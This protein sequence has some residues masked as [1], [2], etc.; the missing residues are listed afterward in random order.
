MEGEAAAFYFRYLFGNGFTRK[1]INKINS[2]LN[3]GY[4]IFRGAIARALVI[5]GFHP[6]L[7]LFHANEHNAFNLADDVIEPFCP[8]VDLYVA[9]NFSVYDS[10]IDL[11]PREEEKRDYVRFR[12][13]I[14]KRWVLFIAIFCVCAF[15]SRIRC[16]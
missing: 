13:F 1:S 15:I 4:S 11:L 7:G 8:V 10:T 2:A 9:K 3:Y 6:S 5:H 16:L 12:S 14:E